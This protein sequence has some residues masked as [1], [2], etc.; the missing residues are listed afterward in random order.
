[1][2]I[3]EDRAVDEV[4]NG[5]KI[6]VNVGLSVVEHGGIKSARTMV[7]RMEGRVEFGAVCHSFATV[8]P[9][10]PVPAPIWRIR[11]G[12]AQR[13]VTAHRWTQTTRRLQTKP[14]GTRRMLC[15]H[16][17]EHTCSTPCLCPDAPV[18]MIVQGDVCQGDAIFSYEG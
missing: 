4:G 8:K 14:T 18:I 1:M 2:T 9:T 10:N 13:A 3:G 17:C 6:G 7:A 5:C 15:N 12:T 11:E 16:L